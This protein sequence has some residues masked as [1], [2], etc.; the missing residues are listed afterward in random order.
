[1]S[2]TLP[3]LPTEDLDF[4]QLDR[5][6]MLLR[7]QTNFNQVNPYWR[8]FSTVHPENLTL[9]G[10]VMQYNV[11]RGV[12]EERVR[13][14]FWGTVTERHS[15]IKM[16]RADNFELTTG[17]APSIAM[18]LTYPGGIAAPK[19]VRIPIRTDT[20]PYGL[21][22]RTKDPTSQKL[23]HLDYAVHTEGSP[24]V[25]KNPVDNSLWLVLA[26]G[27]TSI[28]ATFKGSSVH[29]ASWESNEYPNQE[30]LLN[31]YP[32]LGDSAVLTIEGAV[33]TR[34]TNNTFLGQTPDAKVYIERIDSEGRGRILFGN[35][36]NGQIP[37]GIINAVY[38]AGGGTEAEV[39]A[40]STWT[41]DD[42]VF[43][44]DGEDVLLLASN[45][46][47]SSS[48]FDDMTVAEARVLG[49]LHART[50]ERSVTDSDF[51]TVALKTP[52]IAR[53][54][55]ITSNHDAG[56]E[57][58]TG[59][60]L[61]VGKGDRLTS[62]RYAPASSVSAAK[63]L[64]IST[65]F[66]EDG[67]DEGL[68]GFVVTVLGVDENRYHDIGV[69]VKV[70]KS[71]GAAASD[72]RDAIVEEL[73]D[74]FAV[75]LA[76]LTPNPYMD[77]GAHLKDADGN[78]DRKVLWSDVLRAV[79]GA[80]GVRN[81]SATVDNLLLNGGHTDVLIDVQDFPRLDTGSIL[82]YDMDNGGVLI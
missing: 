34:I 49:P 21:N 75:A 54:A 57:E 43:N 48:V 4:T 39:D 9:E 60:L 11:M 24:N 38:E 77:F 2:S 61:V 19:D 36:V 62:G 65:K 37:T 17:T 63:L 66:E 12:M 81:I 22:I 50:N 82:V 68:M 31:N 25:W 55:M 20:I 28:A 8:D 27:Q 5:N 53:A 30:L 40:G 7:L 58:D 33:W 10:S 79:L 13:Q 59:Y 18:V 70:Y 74:H 76:D 51:E 56:M 46:E 3:L 15:A 69:S 64:E 42:G 16:G 35:G 47:A 72:V 78:V 1:M 73:Q 6:D 45:D 29:E 41:I 67:S 80:N 32:Y 44:E 71:E 52:G 23:Y 26:T 14:L